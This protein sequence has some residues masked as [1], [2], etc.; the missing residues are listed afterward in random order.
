MKRNIVVKIGGSLL[1]KK[2]NSIDT[3]KIKQLGTILQNQEHIGKCVVVCGG[4]I[5]ARNYIDVVREFQSNEALCDIIGIKVSRINSLLFISYLKDMAYPVVPESM[6]QLA[7]ALL[8]KKIVVMGGLQTGQSTTSVALEVGEYIN[9]SQIV[10]LTDVDGI[11]DKDPRKEKDAKLMKSL[12][13]Q[14]LQDL[15]LSP[16]DTGQAAAGE[17]RIFDAVSLQIL[18][19]SRIPVRVMNGNKT[20]QFQ[21]FWNGNEKVTHTLITPHKS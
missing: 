2:E 11:Y 1:F 5:L 9:A 10:I 13:P 18:K 15:I 3:E 17:Y 7:K 6:E 16:Q 8:S 21:K 4:G 14:Q 19:R 12:T 20:E